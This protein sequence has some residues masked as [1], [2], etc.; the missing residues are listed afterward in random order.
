MPELSS[1]TTF[2]SAIIY[3]FG[4]IQNYF[5]NKNFMK[6][7]HFMCCRIVYLYLTLALLLV[8]KNET[9][10]DSINDH[11]TNSEISCS[12]TSCHF[13]SSFSGIS[14][15]LSHLSAQALCEKCIEKWEYVR[16][17]RHWW[18]LINVRGSKVLNFNIHLESEWMFLSQHLSSFERAVLQIKKTKNPKNQKKNK[19]PKKNGL[20][21]K[22]W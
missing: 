22:P 8:W 3:C 14:C 13:P 1:K 9:F 21:G 15:P 2:T 11:V 10:K 17:Y 12:H 18:K 4:Q 5:E 20:H 6:G 7:A 16:V 19:P